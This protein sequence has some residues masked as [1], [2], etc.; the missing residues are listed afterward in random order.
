[1]TR[2]PTANKKQYH[3]GVVQGSASAVL[4]IMMECAPGQYSRIAPVG[5]LS[6]SRRRYGFVRDSARGTHASSQSGGEAVYGA[7]SGAGWCGATPVA[8]CGAA[9]S[10]RRLDDVAR[11]DG[12]TGERRD[13]GAARTAGRRSGAVAPKRPVRAHAERARRGI[14][15]FVGVV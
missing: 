15:V 12:R 11:S 4:A 13:A 3:T 14:I 7:G 2:A 1:M 8:V 9:E 10:T 5:L 6:L